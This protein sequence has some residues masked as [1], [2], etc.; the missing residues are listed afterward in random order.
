MKK[1]FV[2]LLTVLCLA[3]S[4]PLGVSAYDPMLDYD[5]L[6]TPYEDYQKFQGQNIT[7]NV[8]N[9]GEYISDGSDDAMDVNKEFE[10]LTGVHVNYLMFASNEELFAKM[11]SGGSSYDV[12]IP[13]D[14]MISRLQANGLLL[15]LDYGNIPNIANV[16]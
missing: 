2:F 7:I 10:A 15:P 14:Y 13:S 9:W 8:Y 12:V 1:A 4:L 6:D 3:L 5:A 16:D 11:K